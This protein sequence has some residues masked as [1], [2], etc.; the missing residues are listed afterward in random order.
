MIR[1]YIPDDLPAIMKIEREAFPKSTYPKEAFIGWHSEMPDCLLVYEDEKKAVQGYIMFW[2]EGH[3]ASIAVAKALQRKGIGT[4]LLQEVLERA[5]CAWVEVRKGNAGAIS[6]YK[7][8][9]FFEIDQIEGYYGNEDA[10]VMV[11]P[12]KD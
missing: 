7:K 12:V 11:R 1:Q 10:L 6:F 5:G 4:T 2:P 8:H 9:G 3:I